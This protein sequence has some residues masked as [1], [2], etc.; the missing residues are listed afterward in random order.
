MHD[1]AFVGGAL[2]ACIG[3]GVRIG[4]S[5]DR[6]LGAAPDSQAAETIRCELLEPWPCDVHSVIYR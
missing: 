1:K 2:L 3:V 6:N 5:L 4:G